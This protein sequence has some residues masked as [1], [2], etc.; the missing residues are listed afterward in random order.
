MTKILIL[1]S[2]A[3]NITQPPVPGINSISFPSISKPISI[4]IT[5]PTLP[6]TPNPNFTDKSTNTL[7][8]SITQ[9]PI[10]SPPRI[11]LP[12][13]PSIDIKNISLGSSFQIPNITIPTI[14]HLSKP[15]FPN[16]NM[17]NV[18]THFPTAFNI[19]QPPVPGIN[20]ISFPS[21]SKP[22]SIHIT[23][24]TLPIT[25]NPNFTDKST[26]T[27]I[28]GITQLSI[29]SPPR[30]ILPSPPSIDIKNISLGS[31]FQIPN[32]TIPTIPHLSKTTFPTINMTQIDTYFPT[33]LN[34][35]QPPV[36]GI[37]SISFPSISKPISTHI[38]KPTLPIIPNPNFADIGTNR[39]IPG[40]TQLPIIPP[41]QIILPT[42]TSIGI[43]NILIGS[44]SK[45]QIQIPNLPIPIPIPTY[46]NQPFLI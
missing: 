8:P 30:I 24:P 5:K 42:P 3:F 29:T 9:L 1:F 23:K 16:I 44:S 37:N 25:P 33:A 38:T 2:T 14:P 36:P 17:T 21:I 26:N 35:T 4:H 46:Q 22:I 39:L 45:F 12:S 15:T 19:T 40:I 13:P 31:S 7:I 18:H 27:L 43:K 34:I 6:I 20:S 11:I 32:I 10:T 41:P 28:P